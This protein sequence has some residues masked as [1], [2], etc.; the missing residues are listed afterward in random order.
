MEQEI[1][2]NTASELESGFM[3]WSTRIVIGQCHSPRF[4]EQSWYRVSRQALDMIFV[5][6]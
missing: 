5:I 6:L 2:R 4:L 3:R 1:G